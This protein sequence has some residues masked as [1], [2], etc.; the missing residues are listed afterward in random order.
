MCHE[1]NFVMAYYVVKSRETFSRNFRRPNRKCKALSF[2]ELKN[3]QS[4]DFI[5]DKEI[6]SKYLRSN[7]DDI[8]GQG[9][10][11]MGKKT[12]VKPNCNTIFKYQC[13]NP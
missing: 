2:T 7:A 4:V 6:N 10:K 3:Y 9:E 11:L 1:F 13:Q 5:R 12:D 8:I